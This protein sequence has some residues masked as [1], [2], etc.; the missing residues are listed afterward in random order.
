M[1]ESNKPR[2]LGLDGM[3]SVAVQSGYIAIDSSDV[4]SGRISQSTYLRV[5]REGLSR[6]CR[7]Q[8]VLKEPVELLVAIPSA[9]SH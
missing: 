1:L 8:K 5:S 7:S 2:L 6:N 3:V 9:S 4:A